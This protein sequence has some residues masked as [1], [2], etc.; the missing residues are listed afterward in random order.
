DDSAVMRRLLVEIFRRRGGD[1][2]QPMELC[3]AVP[4]GA[5][6][7]HAVRTQHPDVVLL[8]LHMP[9][10]GGM[11]TIDR[12]RREFPKLPIIMCSAATESGAAATL[13]ALA[14]GASD[15]VTK[16]TS[17]AGPEETMALLFAE[18]APR[19]VAL[20]TP[21]PLGLHGAALYADDPSGTR[22]KIEAVGIGL[23]TG[24]PAALEALIAN[25]PENFPVPIVVAQHMP[26][27]FTSALAARLDRVG[28][29][30]VKQA[31]EGVTMRP[32]TVWIAPGDSHMEVKL[33]SHGLPFLA[34]H[35][36][37][38]VHGCRPSVDVL[39]RSL[40][41]C[42]GASAAGLVLTGMGADGLNG[43]SAI[44]HAGGVVLA[45]DEMSSAVWGMPGRVVSAGLA[46]AVV[47]LAGMADALLE[48]T[49]SR[50]RLQ[51]P[52]HP[53]TERSVSYGKFS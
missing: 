15:Y 47:P 19:I 9:G 17:S 41:H 51:C 25:L 48:L 30:R 2:S 11:E 35:D 8:D 33:G 26:R 44:V 42:Y 31:S 23:S 5:S 49:Q 53:S 45:Q 28:A 18:L 38:L 46:A 14:R 50:P 10:F 32:G 3:A 52:V 40:A 12:L 22:T 4:D 29:L 27:L 34:L 20:T 43:A 6:C 36:D 16:P 7:L 13:E 21:A 1:V 37:D 24:G 39:F